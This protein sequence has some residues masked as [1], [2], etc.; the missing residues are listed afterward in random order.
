[1]IWNEIAG[2][3]EKAYEQISLKEAA[4]VFLTTQKQMTLYWANASTGHLLNSRS[5]RTV[6]NTSVRDASGSFFSTHFWISLHRANASAGH[7]LN[8][9]SAHTVRNMLEDGPVHCSQHFIIM[10]SRA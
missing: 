10:Q 8:G 5:A 6:W 9:G 7:V 1:M 4:Q 3:I 2:C